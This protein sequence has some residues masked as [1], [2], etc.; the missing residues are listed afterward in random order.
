[1]PWS[2]L[3]R[4]LMLAGGIDVVPD[5]FALYDNGNYLYPVDELVLAIRKA[6]PEADI[7]S[8]V[9]AKRKASGGVT[10]PRVQRAQIYL[11]V[12]RFDNAVYYRRIDREVF[13]MLTAVRNGDSTA[14]VIEKDLREEQTKTRRPG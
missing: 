4:D 14:T 13:L 8:N 5:V 3:Q 6:T 1:M 7:A 11:A 9:V 10:L 12:H 2:V